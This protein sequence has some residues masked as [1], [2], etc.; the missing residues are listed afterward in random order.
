[1]EYLLSEDFFNSLFI[2]KDFAFLM[3]KVEDDY[4][5][6]RLNQA[7]RDLLSNEA[8][9][10]MISSVTSERIFSIIQKNY[11]QAIREHNQVDYVDYAY[12]QS[13]VHKYET[14]VRPLKYN[15]EDYILA[16]TK[17]ILYDR[18]IEDKFL[19]MRSMFDHAFFSTVILS[20]EGM[21]YEV[22]SCFI[23]DFQLDNETV[24]QKLFVDLPIIPK[25]EIEHIEACLQKAARGE[26]L[27]KKLIKLFTSEGQ[28]RMYLMS[29]SPVMQDD[30]SFAIFLIMQDFTQFTLQKAELR[31]KSHGLEVFKSALNSATAIA[32]LDHKGYITEASDMF[33]QASGYTAE[34]LIGQP[35][36]LMEP[37]FNAQNFLQLI[38]G[39]LDTM[40]IW[41]GE[42]CYRTKYHADYWVEATIVPLK[43]EFGK[44]EQILT[45]NYN[46][47]DKKK[48]FTELKNIERTFRLITENTNDLIVITNEDGI[49]LYASPSYGIYLGYENEELL[50]QFYSDILDQESKNEWQTF[51]N[52]FTGQPETQF[53]LLLKAKD[54]TPIWT[55]GNVTVVHD[56][57]REKVSQI[58]MVSREITHRKERENDLLYLAYHDAL[59]QLPNRRYLQKEFPKILAKAAEN[60][61]CVAMLYLD[62]D[63]FKEVN[64]RFGH[65]TGDA[66]IQR[67]GNAL[68]QTVRSHDMVIRIGGDEF[69]VIL[70]GLTREADK[71][72]DQIMHIIRRIRDE[73]AEGWMIEDHHFTPTASIGIAYYP[74]HAQ[75]L[76]ELMD[77]ADR[78]LY[79]SKELGKNNL[80]ISGAQ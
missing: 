65:D 15:N 64:D 16:I 19:F 70:T 36:S 46:I 77:L 12:F 51:L 7:A 66:F 35:Y 3:K 69:I 48:M 61:T 73:L 26:N 79:R 44:V 32:V 23:E 74:D 14:S 57:E 20:A 40:E 54:G 45:I 55:E 17:E 25:E 8:I 13:E 29:L 10:K 62:G 67:F 76:D 53:E 43:N 75:T 50:G 27:D 47:T 38:E 58:M 34:E 24:K 11:D 80:S 39:K 1:M 60:Q 22:N 37:R 2:G 9:G 18:N 59:T 72:H 4:Q 5:Y 78:A 28:E 63:D 49:I 31:S 56:P 33:L 6:I 41:R 30:N 21:V 68:N 52:N 71:R 42:L